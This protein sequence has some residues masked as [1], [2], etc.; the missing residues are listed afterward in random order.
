MPKN[1]NLM[2]SFAT[3]RRYIEFVRNCYLPSL[4]LPYDTVQNFV[5]YVEDLYHFELHIQSM[6][7]RYILSFLNT[8]VC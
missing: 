5:W 1:F 8:A 4:S 7:S 6:S 2:L 3:I